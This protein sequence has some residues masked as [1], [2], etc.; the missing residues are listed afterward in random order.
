MVLQGVWP[1][2]SQQS[3]EA[4]QGVC[5]VALRTQS[6]LT[7]L[8]GRALTQ[9]CGHWRHP[10]WSRGQGHVPDALSSLRLLSGAWQQGLE[11][12]M[13]QHTQLHSILVNGH[14]DMVRVTRPQ[15]EGLVMVVERVLAQWHGYP[16]VVVAS[17]LRTTARSWMAAL[18]EKTPSPVG[19]LRS[20]R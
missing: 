15:R 12:T 10:M 11:A 3:L 8:Q 1:L 6:G 5:Q 17:V 13:E 2:W 19:H 20:R 7:A 9:V 16:S 4:L 18:E 14:R